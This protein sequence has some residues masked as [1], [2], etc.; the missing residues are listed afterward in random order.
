V[1]DLFFATKNQQYMKYWPYLYAQ[2]H[3]LSKFYKEVEKERLPL[4]VVLPG[5]VVFCLDAMNFC[6]NSLYGGWTVTGTPPYISIDGVI[7]LDNVYSGTIRNG[8]IADDFLGRKYDKNGER[9]FG[10]ST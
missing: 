3:L 7:T 6:A 10:M 8:V 2:S 4:L 5:R 9:L 1:G